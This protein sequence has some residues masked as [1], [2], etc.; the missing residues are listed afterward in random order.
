VIRALLLAAARF[1]WRHPLRLVLAITGVALGIAVFVGV[2]LAN[3]SAR[4]AFAETESQLVGRATHAL[5][6]VGGEVPNALYRNLRRTFGPLVAAPVVEIEVRIPERGT[7]SYVLLGI[8]P[9]EELAF[10][11]YA[12][13]GAP[14]QSAA[15]GLMADF[16]SVLVPRTLA[17]ELGLEIGAQFTLV[18]EGLQPTTLTIAGFVGT[19]DTGTTTANL[20]LVADIATVQ[21]LTDRDTLTR[22]DLLLDDREAR[23]IEALA[24]PGVTLQAAASRS[25]VFVE[26]SRAFATNLTAL[27]LLALL[28][29]VFL[30][31]AT[32]S[33]AVLQRRRDFG[34]H[35]ALGT[36]RRSVL[37]SVLLEGAVLGAIAGGIGL[38]LGVALSRELLELVLRTIGDLYFSTSVRAVAPS[39]GLYALGL[40]VAIVTSVLAAIIPAIE[41]TRIPPHA[42][43]SR[44]S[45]ERASRRLATA[46]A[47]LA[48]PCAAC[49]WLA[50]QVAPRSLTGAF[51]GLFLIIVAVA[52]AIPYAAG[53]LLRAIEPVLAASF[54][55]PSALAVRG[56]TATLSRT[57]VATAALA[58]AVGTVI[59]IG[60]MIGGFRASVEQWLGATLLADFYVEAEGIDAAA[61]DPFATPTIAKLAALPGT[62]GLSLLQ[63]D[64]L[65][66][67]QGLVSIRAVRPGPDGWGLTL[68]APTIDD[69]LARVAAGNGVLVSEALAYRRGIVTGDAIELPTHAGQREFTVLGIYREYN[70]D[71]GGVLLSMAEYQ[72]HWQDRT[73]DGI[74]IYLDPSADREAMSDSVRAALATAPGSTVRSTQAIR[75]RSLEVFDR[76]FKITEVLRLLAA[77][78]AFFGLLTALLSIEL[79]RAKEIAVLR[80][81]GL[82][83]WQTGQLSLVQTSL[84]GAAAGLLAVPLGIVMAELLVRVINRRSFGWGMDLAIRAEPIAAGVALA[85]IAAVLA[86]VYPALRLSRGSIV[87]GLREE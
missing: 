53:L 85:V 63:F 87:A 23:A 9:V 18:P 69:A 11:Q 72:R 6:G 31:Y 42:A 37:A 66:T 3:D 75:E 32:I 50:I 41:A 52:L 12:G 62:R 56:V 70:T 77:T 83:P 55:L 47:W 71:G 54:G 57:G 67:A 20:P 25:A 14:N 36:P 27:S 74:G 60:L 81:L 21:A 86:G 61:G 30:I 15:L 46:A 39:R 7:E 22:I 79:E 59:G 28:V 80:A 40:A 43:L 49:G 65:P 82:S 64:R 16:G 4:R 5:V 38:A 2:E 44:A 26:L 19:A 48:V 84:L 1:Y 29:G 58:V 78:V 45:L 10:R 13:A 76:T 8:D 35:R 24:L 73:I 17:Q 51:A 33:F 68:L 34:I